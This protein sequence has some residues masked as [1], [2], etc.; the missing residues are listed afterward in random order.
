MYE[1]SHRG[2]LTPAIHYSS[3]IC[4]ASVIHV[5]L[6]RRHEHLLPPWHI[7]RAE[8]GE[9]LR[10]RTNE[11]NT[12]VCHNTVCENVQKQRINVEKMSVSAL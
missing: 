10:L 12:Y 7:Y 11:N 2:A 3:N 5:K 9:Q 4:W 1:G 6:R 8:V